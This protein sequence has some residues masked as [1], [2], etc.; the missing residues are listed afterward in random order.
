MALNLFPAYRGK[1]FL[2][3]LLPDIQDF[4]TGEVEN[5]FLQR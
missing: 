3:H 4:L 1:T 2:H 5:E